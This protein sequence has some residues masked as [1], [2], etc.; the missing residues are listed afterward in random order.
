MV[1]DAD[2]DASPPPVADGGADRSGETRAVTRRGVMR[3]AAAAGTA[4][5]LGVTGTGAAAAQ[6]GPDYGGWFT[7]NAPGGAVDNYDGTTVDRTGQ[8]TVTVEVGAD[9]NGGTFAFA[10]AAVRVSP[11]TTVVFEWTSNTHNVLVEEQPDGAGWEGHQ[12][13]ED[14]GFS[15]EHVFDTEGVYKYYCEPHLS[16]G[17]KGAIVVGG[18][19]DGGGGGEGQAT[20]IP[21]EYGGWFTS[22]ASG[23]AVDN[24]DGTTADLRGQDAVTVEVGADGNGGTFAFAPPAV[25]VSPGTTLTFEWTSNTHN[26]LVEEQPDGAGWEGHQPIEDQGFSFEAVLETP[27]IYKYYCE[28]HLSLGMK[29]AIIV[30]PAA[31]AEGG[32]EGGGEEV[33]PGAARLL[34]IAQ[35]IVGTVFVG[36]LFVIGYTVIKLDRMEE[37]GE[38]VERVV[39]ETA[40]L[41]APTVELAH[42]EYDPTGT[43]SLILAYFGI[44]V[45][46]WVFMYFVEFLNH[47]PTVMG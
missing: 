22:D 1:M 37:P 7:S 26:V 41:E 18:G 33:D 11:G 39:T 14:Q 8:D 6:S 16:L 2:P 17:M 45:L 46:M 25:R 40:P 12:P 38:T 43:F 10:P 34:N 21:A 13:I 32:G 27:G 35:G 44:L 3:S 24:Y 20:P 42:D 36:L 15:F 29:G 31:P 47:G 19:G 4:L 28:P 23:G 5:G 9:G 30:D